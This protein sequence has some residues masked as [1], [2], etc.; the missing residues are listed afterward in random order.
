MYHKSDVEL[1]G[2]QNV[3]EG[4]LVEETPVEGPVSEGTL[5]ING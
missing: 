1:A 3:A 4:T 5:N 2:Q